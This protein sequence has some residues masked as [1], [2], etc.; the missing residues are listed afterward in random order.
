MRP[1]ELKGLSCASYECEALK[2]APMVLKKSPTNLFVFRILNYR[3]FYALHLC[4]MDVT[5]MKVSFK[6]PLLIGEISS[7]P[8]NSKEDIQNQEFFDV[9]Q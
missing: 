1:F 9:I 3:N 8:Y 7:Y 5:L 2:K 4:I 6:K